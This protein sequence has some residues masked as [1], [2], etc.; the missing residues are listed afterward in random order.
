MSLTPVQMQ[1]KINTDANFR[2]LVGTF[3]QPAATGG[4]CSTKQRGD[5]CMESNCIGGQKI[6]MKC[7]ASGG[8]TDYEV[9]PC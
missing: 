1:Q 3:G 7:D 2:N 5:I 9:V 4:D 6:V 8:C